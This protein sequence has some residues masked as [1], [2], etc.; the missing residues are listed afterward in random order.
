LVS[1]V[2]PVFIA[3]SL[4]VIVPG[5]A[6]LLA[7]ALA[8]LGRTYL[9][10]PALLLVTALSVQHMAVSSRGYGDFRGAIATVGSHA[11]PGDR[12]LVVPSPQVWLTPRY[13]LMHNP[14]TGDVELLNQPGLERGDLPD[15][16]HPVAGSGQRLWMLL[17][18]RQGKTDPPGA[19]VLLR[20]M[21]H[22]GYDVVDEW[23]FQRLRLL[24]LDDTKSVS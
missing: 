9:A 22:F 8:A 7:A 15:L 23:R 10:V 2:H 19:A 14:S 12:L 4:I 21:G 6:L 13:Y 18:L 11:E 17:V 16:L 5:I 24:L 1:L 3:R 20:R